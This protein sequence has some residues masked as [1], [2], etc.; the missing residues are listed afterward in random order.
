[1]PN[2]ERY[3]VEERANGDFAVKGEGKKRA[4]LVETSETAATDRSGS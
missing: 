1:M 3:F 4:A 2:P